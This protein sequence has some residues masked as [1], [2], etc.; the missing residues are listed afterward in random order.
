MSY[1][2]AGSFSIAGSGVNGAA[3]S[4]WD[5]SRFGGQPAL[6]DAPPSGSP[7]ATATTGTASGFNGSFTIALP[8]TDEYYILVASGGINY[9]QGPVVGA[10]AGGGGLY[11]SLTGPGEGSTPGALTQAGGFTVSDPASQGVYLLGANGTSVLILQH[12]SGESI[13]IQLVDYS[14]G[15]IS[16]ISDGGDLVLSG[17]LVEIEFTNLSIQGLPSTDPL[18]YREAWDN[19]G[20]LA[21]STGASE[22]VDISG[23][24][25]N[26]WSASGGEAKYKQQGSIVWVV[27]DLDGSGASGAAW[28][29]L[30]APTSTVYPG[31]CAGSNGGGQVPCYHTVANP[32]GSVSTQVLSDNSI[33]LSIAT[34]FSYVVD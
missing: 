6:G 27:A 24:L 16:I 19:H 20:L 2:Y 23:S 22:W 18:V 13:A 9:W 7:D 15:G 28:A 33:P 12:A 17:L 10:G 3:V 25:L 5:I 34:V 21:V 31:V 8:T 30:P 26:G 32:S 14:A 1:P 4:A 11:A 29:D